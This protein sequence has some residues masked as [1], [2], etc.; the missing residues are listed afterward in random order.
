M[1]ILLSP[2]LASDALFE[3]RTDV[4]GGLSSDAFASYRTASAQVRAALGLQRLTRDE[5]VEVKRAVA[6]HQQRCANPPLPPQSPGG[7]R[8]RAEERLTSHVGPL[9]R[10]LFRGSAS[11]WAGGETEVQVRVGY[12]PAACGEARR[13]WSR[14]GK[15]SG[16]NA[17]LTITVAPNWRGAVKRVVGLADAG[18]MLTTHARQIEPGLWDAAWVR[19][20]RGFALVAEDGFIAR[21][22]DGSW[23]HAPT[24]AAAHCRVGAP[25]CGAADQ[26]VAPRLCALRAALREIADGERIAR[27]GQLV[28]QTGDSQRAGNCAAGTRAFRERHFPG[29]RG[30]S[31]AEV[32]AVARAGGLGQYARRA[33]DTAIL[34]QWQRT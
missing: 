9:A 27:F 23:V 5:I 7:V 21:A 12:A 4:R 3:N 17:L 24:E 15:W 22:A 33:C 6:R 25:P 13:T 14:N 8:Q 18:G 34:C 2:R 30:A 29:C 11:T 32:L 26:D 1:Q 16:T 19:Q 31:V 20:G 10:R 28:S